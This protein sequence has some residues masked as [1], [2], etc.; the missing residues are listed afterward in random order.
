MMVGKTLASIFDKS[1]NILYCIVKN[2][3]R[4]KHSQIQLF[5]LFGGEKFGEW[6]NNDKW[7]LKIP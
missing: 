7:I 4:I 3:G 6:P 2:I 5:R 1:K